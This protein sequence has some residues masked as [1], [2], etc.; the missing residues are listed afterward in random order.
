MKAAELA[1]TSLFF[2]LFNTSCFSQARSRRLLQAEQGSLEDPAQGRG[3]ALCSLLLGRLV[4]LGECHV[5]A[6]IRV[7]VFARL[8]SRAHT[9]VLP[10]Q[11]LNAPTR[12]IFFLLFI[13]YFVVVFF[14][15]IIYYLISTNGQDEG[16]GGGCGM[17]RA[18]PVFHVSP[19][20]SSRLTHSYPIL[21][22]SHG[23]LMSSHPGY[24]PSSPP[25]G[26]HKHAR[27]LLL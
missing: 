10:F 5:M 13:M 26:H 16:S 3:L 18:C 12:R 11:L 27:R 8:Y 15:A 17:V 21:L 19:V 6:R 25:P 2:K 7:L 9:P 20:L 24:V 23:H 4:P 14:Y 1:S 22:S